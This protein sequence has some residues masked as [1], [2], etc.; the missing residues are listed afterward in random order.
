M[1][2]GFCEKTAKIMRKKAAVCNDSLKLIYK[3]CGAAS[4]QSNHR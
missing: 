1:H 2:V 3:E 4:N